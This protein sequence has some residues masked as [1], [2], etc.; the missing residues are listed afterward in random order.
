MGG[1]TMI[2]AFYAVL[3]IF[4]GYTLIFGP[5]KREKKIREM[6]NSL[7]VGTEVITSGGIIGKIVNIKDDEI[8][9]ETGITRTQI[10]IK[11]WAVQEAKKP[12]QE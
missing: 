1:Q 4:M 9:I 7:E 10:K 11:K 8:T 5:K 2:F 3:I 6:L 12:A